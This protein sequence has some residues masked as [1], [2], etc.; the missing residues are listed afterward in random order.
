MSPAALRGGNPLGIAIPKALQSG[1]AKM[2]LHATNAD[3]PC[4]LLINT[5]NVGDTGISERDS[6][7]HW[8]TSKKPEGKPRDLLTPTKLEAS[9]KYLML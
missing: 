3:A 7:L 1:T 9:A 8:G 6:G 5:G 2:E 4:C